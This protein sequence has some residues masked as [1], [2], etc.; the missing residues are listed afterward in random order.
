MSTN[1]HLRNLTFLILALCIT[2]TIGCD[3]DDVS[4]EV[5]IEQFEGT[6]KAKSMIFTNNADADQSFAFIENGGE[7]RFTVLPGG[8]VRTWVE[9]DTFYDEW[10]SQAT[11]SGSTLTSVPVE[12]T[13]PIQVITFLLDGGTLTMTNADDRFDFTFSGVAGVSAT[14]VGVFERQ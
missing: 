5:T 14:N 8:R 7:V 11:L 12:E 3:D 2:V 9:I 4:P 6:W 13:R 10:D 1:N